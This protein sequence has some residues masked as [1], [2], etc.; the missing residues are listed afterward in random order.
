[1]VI[2]VVQVI[3]LIIQRNISHNIN[4]QVTNLLQYVVT[5]GLVGVTQIV[6]DTISDS[7]IGL[8]I[9]PMIDL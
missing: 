2:K 1:M 9:K 5:H 7:N 3:L 4:Q 6:T 8:L